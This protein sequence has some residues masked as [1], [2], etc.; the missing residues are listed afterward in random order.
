MPYEKVD[1]EELKNEVF[2]PWL[3]KEKKREEEQCNQ[4]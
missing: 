1:T 4:S 3:T 2:E